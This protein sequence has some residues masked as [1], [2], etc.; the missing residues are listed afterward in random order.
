MNDA[1]SQ[2]VSARSAKSNAWT[3]LLLLAGILS[4]VFVIASVD[5]I[6]T[7]ISSQP[8]CVDHEHVGSTPA[9]HERAPAAKSA[10]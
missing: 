4:I 7:A 5:L 3:F 9:G 2:S 10:C 8:A 1:S 6:R